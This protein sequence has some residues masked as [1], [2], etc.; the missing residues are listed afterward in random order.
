MGCLSVTEEFLLG[1]ATCWDAAGESA[2]FP[3]HICRPPLVRRR[4]VA[5][6]ASGFPRKSLEHSQMGFSSFF[7]N[8]SYFYFG[9]CYGVE[10][11][12]QKCKVSRLL[13]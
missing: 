2:L 6:S 3:A 10:L 5:V 13:L 9:D 12:A 4:R 7:Q 11:R 1:G 8:I